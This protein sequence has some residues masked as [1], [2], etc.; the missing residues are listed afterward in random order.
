V[1]HLPIDPLTVAALH[2][3]TTVTADR[4][5]YPT[6]SSIILALTFLGFQ[7]FYLAGTGA[8]GPL[9]PQ[10][11]P[12]VI[13]HGIA[14]T[15]WVVLV[16]V[17]SLLIASRN[18]RLHMKLGSSA[19]V[20]APLVAITGTWVAIAGTRLLPDL[21]IAGYPRSQFLLVLLAQMLAFS[22]FVGLGLLMRKKPSRHRAM[23]LM[24]T[25]TFLPP[26]TTRI[27]FFGDYFGV[28]GWWSMNGPQFIFGGLLLVVRIIID[29]SIDR[30][31]ALGYVGLVSLML[32]SQYLAV[33]ESWAYVAKAILQN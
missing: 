26:V 28:E 4:L 29:R 1:K 7:R 24:A 5:F 9:T 18:R 14:S 33:R 23:I 17:Q 20:V 11:A 25:M 22:A 13:V 32:A 2:S 15:A 3:K 19:L 21:A 31:F 12:L 30:W 10:I 16:F 8:F 27:A 6:A